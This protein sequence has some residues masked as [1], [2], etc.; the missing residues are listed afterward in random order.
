M[1]IEVRINGEKRSIPPG[2]TLRALLSHLEIRQ[3][4]VAVEYNREIV[5]PDL[6]DD[7]MIQPD[8]EIEVVHFVGGGC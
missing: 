3:E 7:R 2:L 4:R 6:W 8:D 1:P 5:K